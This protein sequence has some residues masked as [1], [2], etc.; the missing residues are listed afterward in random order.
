M[1]SELKEYNS[2]FID[3]TESSEEFDYKFNIES[4]VKDYE[5][6]FAK[7]IGLYNKYVFSKDEL[8]F[9]YYCREIILKKADV[10]QLLKLYLYSKKINNKDYLLISEF[11]ISYYSTIKNSKYR[12]IVANY[13]EIN[14]DYKRSIE[15]HTEIDKPYITF[16]NNTF[17]FYNIIIDYCIKSKIK[18]SEESVERICI[19]LKADSSKLNCLIDKLINNNI[20]LSLIISFDKNICKHL[21]VYNN[22]IKTYIN[23]NNFYKYPEH[24]IFTLEKN[25][26]LGEDT[27]NIIINNIIDKINTL[28]KI[29]IKKQESFI[30]LL[31]LIDDLN[32]LINRFMQRIESMNKIQNQKLCECLNNLLTIKRYIVSDETY[33]DSQLRKISYETVMPSKEINNTVKEISNNVIKLFS[34]SIMNFEHQM[35]ETLKIYSEN[36]L[37]SMVN[38]FT[39]DSRQQMYYKPNEIFV[40]NFFKK[41]YDMIGEKYTKRN[42][43][44]VNKL[45]ENYY[46]EMLKNLSKSFL[47]KQN[48][49]Y[50]FLKKEEK[51]DYIIIELKK[52]FNITFNDYYVIMV[53]NVLH[54]EFLVLELLAKFNLKITEDGRT[55]LYTIAEYFKEDKFI[56]NGLMYINY[57]LYEITGLNI[58]NAAAHGA[59]INKNIDIELMLTFCGVIFMH[60]LITEKE[61]KL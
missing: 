48:L 30:Q 9:S 44:L 15:Q 7:F 27:L 4:K 37:I 10:N 14:N 35:K 28:Y 59:L 36:A 61:R 19:N 46:E 21:D 3:L 31:A 16:L 58:R 17:E 55:N 6:E 33:I 23:D 50:S 47:M 56:I 13:K 42:K 32:K 34:Y 51:F 26:Q 43:K 8:L 18:I 38:V 52:E 1:L 40:N 22:Y 29:V 57:I 45:I 25:K 53:S 11:I 12:K 24:V 49:L 54:I 2:K 41:Y 20:C 39:I 60:Y 5:F